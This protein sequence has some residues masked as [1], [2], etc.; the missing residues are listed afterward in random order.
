MTT[1]AFASALVFWLA[2]RWSEVT[3]EQIS[4]GAEFRRRDVL[5]VA[6]R[7]WPLVEAA[8]VP[9]WPLVEAAV[10]PTA[11]LAPTWAGVWSR[12]TGA[13]SRSVRPSSRSPGGH[14]S[15]AVAPWSWLRA[16]SSPQSMERSASRY[17]C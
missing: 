7:E 16:A 5:V 8:V 1:T 14:W 17:C 9:E 13:E 15:P 12:E 3:G 11:F 2:H 6:R 4:A 10:V